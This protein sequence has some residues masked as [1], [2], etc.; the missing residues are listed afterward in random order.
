MAE[1]VGFRNIDPEDGLMSSPA[2]PTPL[3]THF[4]STILPPLPPAATSNV[5]SLSHALHPP[6]FPP[7]PSLAFLS[8]YSSPISPALPSPRVPPI[9]TSLFSPHFHFPPISPALSSPHFPLISPD[10]PSPH[11]PFPI[12]PSSFSP[13][14]P[15][16]TS[17][18]FPFFFC[19]S[20]TCFPFSPFSFYFTRLAVSSFA[21]HQPALSNC[22]SRSISPE[23]YSRRHSIHLTWYDGI[24]FA[25]G[26]VV[27]VETKPP[28]RNRRNELHRSI[29]DEATALCRINFGVQTANSFT[30]A[31]N[32]RRCFPKYPTW[33]LTG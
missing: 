8:S 30:I 23:Q 28:P 26:K 12:P 9:S 16:H 32:V 3:F 10:L 14:F 19:P 6:H 21:S 31:R 15:P 33:L 4:S 24:L 22:P 2:L 20:H 27:E 13:H 1:M 29:Q 25:V 18:A 11:S 7:S 5:S 17:F